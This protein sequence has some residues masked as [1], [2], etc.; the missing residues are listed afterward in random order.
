[1]LAAVGVSD[2][3]LQPGTL[4]VPKYVYLAM[5]MK[6]QILVDSLGDRLMQVA[7]E[8]FRNPF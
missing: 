6:E 1:M 5:I 2:I 4:V 8:A 3:S 7:V